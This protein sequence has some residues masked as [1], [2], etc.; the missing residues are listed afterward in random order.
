MITCMGF[1]FTAAKEQTQSDNAISIIDLAK[2]METTEETVRLLIDHGWLHLIS[3]GTVGK[4]APGALI[5]LKQAIG[6]IPM[7]P[8]VPVR[9]LKELLDTTPQAIKRIIL[10]QNIP[11]YLDPVLGELISVAGFHRLFNR[12]YPWHE[13]RRFDRQ[14]MFA[15]LTDIDPGAAYPFYRPLAYDKM[16]EVEMARI[17]KLKEPMRSLRA[18]ELYDAFRDAKTVASIVRKVCKTDLQRRV[19]KILEF[20]QRKEATRLKVKV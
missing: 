2:E 20:Q 17:A 12:L 7:I 8:M 19:E 11:L 3:P 15:I 18:Q 6:P 13:R 5:W 14:M 16:L 4:P 10:D 9:H 1:G